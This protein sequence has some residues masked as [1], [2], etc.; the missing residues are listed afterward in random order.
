MK[1]LN[2]KTLIGLGVFA[3]AMFFIAPGARGLLPLL[4]LAACP[5]M[6]VL[7]MFGASKMKSSGGSC[8]TNQT[9]PQ[10]EIEAK[11]AEIARLEAM[12]QNS[13]RRSFN[14]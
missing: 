1:C 12:L 9:D 8:A 6:M 2:R 13:N 4:L 5:V 3:V 7:M 10:R 14:D 11:N